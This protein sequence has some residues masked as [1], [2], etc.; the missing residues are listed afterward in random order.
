[1]PGKMRKKCDRA[2]YIWPMPPLQ[3][4]SNSTLASFVVVLPLDAKGMLASKVSLLHRSLTERFAYFEVVLV[5]DSGT[6]AFTQDVKD[7]LDR[8][9]FVRYVRLHRSFGEE[10]AGYAGMDQA[11]GDHVVLA[12]LGQDP[13]E[14]LPLVMARCQE[15]ERV[16]FGR[17]LNKPVGGLLRR[18]GQ[19][20][21]QWYASRT[22]RVEL[23]PGLTRLA[24]MPRA[25]VN[26]LLK[27]RDPSGYLSV[28][29]GYAGLHT[30]HH[31]Y[32]LERPELWLSRQTLGE[33]IVRAVNIT[34]Q[35][36]V[37]P[38]RLLTYVG[39]LGLFFDVLYGFFIM[40]IYF[41]M[42]DRAPGWVA[43]SAQQAIYF[44]FI[45]AFFVVIS[46]YLGQIMISVRGRPLYFT[47]EERHSNVLGVLGNKRNVVSE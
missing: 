39:L 6:D 3:E 40:G 12:V 21:F 45:C 27:L 2:V 43:L 9:P 15:T 17:A 8:L 13:M 14:E 46:E 20:L 29:A 1:M 19:R 41:F 36:S 18:T 47:A 11:I 16:I 28:Q 35:N 23:D 31:D 37:H 26:T 7:L 38:L 24:A 30:L 34:A 33:S 4:R 32:L 5:D 44:L 22:L 25:V 42:A 10:I